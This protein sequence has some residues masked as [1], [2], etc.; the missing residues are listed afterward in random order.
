MK[1]TQQNETLNVQIFQSKHKQVF[2]FYAI[3]PHWHAIDNWSPS[4]YKTRTYQ[5]YIINIM[6][7]D[8]LGC[9]DP[10]HQQPWY[11]PS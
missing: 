4:L 2:T 11:W 7:A 3:P 6:A 5:F 10:G 8:V 9:K 1:L